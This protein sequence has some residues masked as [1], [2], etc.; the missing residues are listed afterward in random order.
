M[1]KLGFTASYIRPRVS[2]DNLFSVSL[3][4]GTRS[5][6]LDS[7]LHYCRV[8]LNLA[9]R[10]IVWWKGSILRGGCGNLSSRDKWIFRATA[11]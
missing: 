6:G 8:A 10:Q 1:E 4:R 7:F 11:A 3:R 9:L 5:R 2:N